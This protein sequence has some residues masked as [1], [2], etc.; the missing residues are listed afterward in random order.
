VTLARRIT[1]VVWQ[2][3]AAG[4]AADAAFRRSRLSLAFARGGL[5]VSQQAREE[6]AEML[7]LA[8]VR[9]S[10][11]R[12]RHDQAPRG[13]WRQDGGRVHARRAGRTAERLLRDECQDPRQDPRL[14]SEAPPL[15][16]QDS[17]PEAASRA[18]AAEPTDENLRELEKR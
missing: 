14:T 5:S 4:F 13:L 17:W 7:V 6:D 12:P 11:S 8:M 18:I 3:M 16:G 1:T 2:N 10:P 15:P 9:P